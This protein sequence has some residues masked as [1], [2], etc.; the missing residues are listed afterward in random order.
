MGQV[1]LDHHQK[2]F[3]VVAHF[4]HLASSRNE[5]RLFTLAAEEMK[6][7]EEGKK[8]IQAKRYFT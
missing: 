4:S 5:D 8:R 3:G 2:Q 7:V 1:H 6:H